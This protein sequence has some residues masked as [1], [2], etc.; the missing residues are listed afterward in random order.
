MKN[1]NLY[2]N[3]LWKKSRPIQLKKHKTIEMH[4]S[5]LTVILYENEADGLAI[6]QISVILH[7]YIYFVCK[8]ML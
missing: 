4:S 6:E 1:E 5:P 7:I 8:F 2:V 3:I